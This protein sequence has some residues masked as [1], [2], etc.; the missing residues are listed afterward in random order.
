MKQEIRKPPAR[1]RWRAYTAAYVDGTLSSKKAAQMQAH[2]DSG[3]E[4]C[5]RAVEKEKRLRTMLASSVPTPNDAQI[6]A[7]EHRVLASVRSTPIAAELAK[8]KSTRFRA[9]RVAGGIAASL[10]ILV[11]LTRIAPILLMTA[12]KTAE[13]MNMSGDMLFGKAEN[14]AMASGNGSPS[15]NGNNYTNT[16]TAK[17]ELDGVAVEVETVEEF[18]KEESEETPT[19]SGGMTTPPYDPSTDKF[20][21]ANGSPAETGRAETATETTR[22]TSECEAEAAEAYVY[23]V[24]VAEADAARAYGVLSALAVENHAVIAEMTNGWSTS[25]ELYGALCIALK[26]AAIQNAMEMTQTDTE[27]AQTGLLYLV[28]VP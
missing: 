21:F 23:T 7:I 22:P 17:D 19:A 20:Q 8:K 4:V 6:E 25:A 15:D 18:V 14:E 12:D 11:G 16:Y 28:F 5:T 9:W 3:C 24:T 1:C 2:L 13:D 10:L 27:T 26:D